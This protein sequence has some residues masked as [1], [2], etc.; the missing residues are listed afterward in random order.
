MYVCVCLSVCVCVCVCVS[1]SVCV[2][3]CVAANLNFIMAMPSTPTAF[4]LKP[5]RCHRGSDI[6]PHALKLGVYIH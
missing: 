1:V 3:V 4:D 2:C 5:K 6:A